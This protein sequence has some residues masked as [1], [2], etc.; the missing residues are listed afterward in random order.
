MTDTLDVVEEAVETVARIPKLRLNGTTTKQQ[1]A[2]LTVT[3]LTG[4]VVGGVATYFGNAK[5][6]E[7]KYRLIKDQEVEEARNFY[8]RLGKVGEFSEPPKGPVEEAADASASYA[9]SDEG[10]P[11]N[12]EKG[13]RPR[14]RTDVIDYTRFSTPAAEAPKPSEEDL[15]PREEELQRVADGMVKLHSSQPNRL[16][17]EIEHLFRRSA[18]AYGFDYDAE[19]ER[20]KRLPI[21]APYL[22]TFDEFATNVHDIPQDHLVYWTKDQTLSDSRELVVEKD[23]VGRNN[24]ARFGEG[25]ADPNVVYVHNPVLE[26]DYEISLSQDSYAAA[27]HEIDFTTGGQLEHSDGPPRRKRMR[28]HEG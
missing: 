20:R 26:I 2:I 13:E 15:I 1:V 7:Y 5:R 21:D 25:S 12:P 18:D 16:P 27:V 9:P 28:P 10:K 8:M 19:L 22:I 6:L 23:T 17:A 24:L 3:A 14:I 11:E 4:A